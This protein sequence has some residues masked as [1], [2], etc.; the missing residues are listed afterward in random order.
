M[1]VRSPSAAPDLF[2]HHHVG[3]SGPLKLSADVSSTAIYGGPKDCYRYTLRRVWDDTRPMVMWLMMNPSVATEFGDDRTVAKCQRYARA[4]GYGGM[5]V[6]NSFAYRCTDQK[7]LLEVDDPVGPD[8]DAHLLEMA[9]QA[10]LV[11]LAYGS[12]QAKGLRARGT[13]VARLM[14]QNGIRVTALRLS[15]SGRPEHP[16]YLPSIL[17]PEPLDPDTLG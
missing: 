16:L 14:G 10:D 6:G 15:K 4:W 2:D 9:R 17:T 3:D 11:V 12:P 1:S 5:F 8:N 7:R 13:E